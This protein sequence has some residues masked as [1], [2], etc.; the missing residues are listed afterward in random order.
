MLHADSISFIL[1]GFGDNAKVIVRVCGAT[2]YE[3]NVGISDS[4][5]TM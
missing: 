5:G 3:A 1:E 4:N 2:L